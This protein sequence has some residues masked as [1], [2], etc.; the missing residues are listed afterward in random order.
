MPASPTKPAKAPK[1]KTRIK[2]LESSALMGVCSCGW[3][4][5]ALAQSSGL[6]TAM[7]AVQSEIQAHK[8]LPQPKKEKKRASKAVH[9]SK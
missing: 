3:A 8:H 2:V 1:F 7:A 9:G 4:G 6:A 5:N